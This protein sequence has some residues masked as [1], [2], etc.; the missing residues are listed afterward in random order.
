MTRGVGTG[1]APP[2]IKPLC[3][4]P[5]T[6]WD[7]AE[8][9]SDQLRLCQ[10]MRTPA[11]IATKPFEHAESIRL[12]APTRRGGKPKGGPHPPQSCHRFHHWA[13]VA[14]TTKLWHGIK[15]V[16]THFYTTFYREGGIWSE[17]R[18]LYLCAPPP[19]ARARRRCAGGGSQLVPLVPSVRCALHA[20]SV[21]SARRAQPPPPG[22][23]EFSGFPWRIPARKSAPRAARPPP[24]RAR[25]ARRVG[26]D[27]TGGE[28]SFPTTVS[29]HSYVHSWRPVGGNGV[30]A[31]GFK[32]NAY[33]F[34]ILVVDPH[35][36]Y[37]FFLHSAL[38]AI[39]H[40]GHS[41]YS[42]WSNIP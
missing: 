19:P 17:L 16:E 32:R 23:R 15:L 2:P 11:P 8:S 29:G 36:K 28:S 40:G 9:D 14:R 26:A 6:A 39:C 4:C 38:F 34:C 41:Q 20:A 13:A 21:R 30:Q 42:L 12:L 3:A 37:V 31:R 18:T 22:G 35:T 33:F 10:C 25:A 1:P 24:P 5:R 27:G 7:L